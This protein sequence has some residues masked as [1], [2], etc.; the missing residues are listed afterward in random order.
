MCNYQIRYEQ[1][2]DKVERSVLLETID[3]LGLSQTLYLYHFAILHAAR[4]TNRALLP[5]KKHM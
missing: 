3:A 2:F 4:Q 5:R 1:S